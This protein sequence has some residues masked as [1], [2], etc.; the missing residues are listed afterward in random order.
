MLFVDLKIAF[1][2]VKKVMLKTMRK[3]EVRKSLMKRCKEIVRETVNRV[4]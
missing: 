3:R 2:S 4:R 1:D